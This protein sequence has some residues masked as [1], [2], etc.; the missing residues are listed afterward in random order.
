MLI[1]IRKKMDLSINRPGSSTKTVTALRT[2]LLLVHPDVKLK[3][4]LDEHVTRATLR[5]G[6]QP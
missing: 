5:A 3:R 4:A 1:L 2:I 6:Q